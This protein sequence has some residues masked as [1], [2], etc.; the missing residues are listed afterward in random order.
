MAQGKEEATET[1]D[2][3]YASSGVTAV[4]YLTLLLTLS[5]SF[6]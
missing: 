6:P 5:N 2:T 4:I 1:P 3:T